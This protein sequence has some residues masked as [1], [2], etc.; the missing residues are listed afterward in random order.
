MEV[1]ITISFFGTVSEHTAHSWLKLQYHFASQALF[2]SLEFSD[3]ARQT[4]EMVDG[5]KFFFF[6]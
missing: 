5:V 2:D 4:A 1:S 6:F 3:Y